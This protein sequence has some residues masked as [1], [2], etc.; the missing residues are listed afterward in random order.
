MIKENLNNIITN[1]KKFYYKINQDS[2]SE[3]AAECAFFTILS[4]F[5]ALIFLV[6]ILKYIYID[7]K[8]LLIVI[9]DFIPKMTNDLIIQILE[10]INQKSFKITFFSAIATL[11]SSGKGFFSLNKFFKKIYKDSNIYNNFFIRLEGVIYT[12]LFII[13]FIISLNLFVFG[14][15]F[16]KIIEK[17]FYSINILVMFLLKIKFI[18]II[19]ILFL[20]FM[21]L[22]RFFFIRKK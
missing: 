10:E 4:F 6:S 17:N 3:Y 11:W 1:I 14:S 13:L 12:F 19:L 8:V 9:K 2:I 22:Y 15:F 7:E 18:I 20:I 5:P 21:I 16:E